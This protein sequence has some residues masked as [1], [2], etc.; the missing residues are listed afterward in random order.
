MTK[1]GRGAECFEETLAGL[2]TETTPKITPNGETLPTIDPQRG[3]GIQDG[4]R[5][6]GRR[7]GVGREKGGTSMCTEMYMC[8]IIYMHVHVH[9]HVHVHGHGHVSD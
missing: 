9:V 4:W 8:I 2:G 6:G 1:S 3:T 5:E 7:E